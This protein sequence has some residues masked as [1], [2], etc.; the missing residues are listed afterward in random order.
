MNVGWEKLPESIKVRQ[1]HF[2][3]HGSLTETF[4]KKSLIKN[5]KR[6][7][8]NSKKKTNSFNMLQLP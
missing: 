6:L 3:L 1:L 5:Q 7:Q 2:S 4:S 8:G